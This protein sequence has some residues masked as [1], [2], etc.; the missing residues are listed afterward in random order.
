MVE[1]NLKSKIIRQ[2][3]SPDSSDQSKSHHFHFFWWEG[4]LLLI[5]DFGPPQIFDFNAEGLTIS[6]IGAGRA[7]GD[8][9][10][11]HFQNIAFSPNALA[12]AQS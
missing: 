2:Y 10:A 3:N 9:V 1:G 12:P 8:I 5:F 4:H 6:F 11:A 7:K